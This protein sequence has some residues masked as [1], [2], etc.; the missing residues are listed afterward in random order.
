MPLPPPFLL[1]VLVPQRK[2]VSSSVNFAVST[3]REVLGHPVPEENLVVLTGLVLTPCTMVVVIV[4]VTVVLY[5]S[6]FLPT[7]I[8]AAILLRKKS[9]VVPSTNPLAQSISQ[10][11]ILWKKRTAKLLLL[12]SELLLLLLLLL[13]LQLQL[14]LLLLLL[15]AL[16]DEAPKIWSQHRSFLEPVSVAAMFEET[17]TVVLSLVPTVFVNLALWPTV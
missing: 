7:Y 16:A 15:T 6:V 2:K 12:L 1:E 4:S 11:Q 10:S 14:L 8:N 13:D 5:P 9:V 3:P 17:D